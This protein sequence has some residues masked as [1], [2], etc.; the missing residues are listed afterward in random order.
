[1]RITRTEGHRIQQASTLDAQRAAKKRGADVVKQWDSTLDEEELHILQERASFFGLLADDRKSFG[2][3]KEVDFANFKE[4]YLNASK[5]IE[6]M[7][8]SGKKVVD[9]SRKCD[10]LKLGNKAVREW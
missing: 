7:S 5:A 10:T 6:E 1:M 4:N 2:E 8:N 9:Y 3:A